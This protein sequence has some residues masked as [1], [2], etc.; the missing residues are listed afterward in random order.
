MWTESRQGDLELCIS[1]I[2]AD[3]PQLQHSGMFGTGCIALKRGFSALS[4]AKVSYEPSQCLS[5][6]NVIHDQYKII[7]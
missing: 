7:K 4:R 6:I 2:T 1:R 3:E 5:T